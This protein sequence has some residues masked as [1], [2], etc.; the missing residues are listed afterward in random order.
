MEL[1]IFWSHFAKLKLE[2]IYRYYRLRAGKKVATRIV[3]GI[4]EQTI[5]LDGNPE[6]G[7]VESALN[8]KFREF[9]YLVYTNYKIIYY[10]NKVANRIVIAN[11]F[12]TRQNPDKIKEMG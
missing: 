9:R 7:Q 8:D 5:I 4:V 12:D 3:D 2:E 6:I 11:V 10:I 1:D